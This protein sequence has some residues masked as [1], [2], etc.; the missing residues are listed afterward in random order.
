VAKTRNKTLTAGLDKGPKCNTVNKNF[1][2]RAK[3]LGF[4][5][6]NRQGNAGTEMR[7]TYRTTRREAKKAKKKLL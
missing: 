2:G 1:K 6:S 5:E 4:E 7:G 3:T